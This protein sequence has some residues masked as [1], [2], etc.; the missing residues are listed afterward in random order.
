MPN[1]YKPTSPLDELAPHILQYWKTRL[2][3]KEIILALQKHFDTECYGI[4]LTKFCQIRVDM[5]LKRLRQQG[6]T[7]ETICEAVTE[8]WEMFPHAGA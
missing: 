4:G 8:L 2:N 3:D 5:G 1:Q 6:H 7:I